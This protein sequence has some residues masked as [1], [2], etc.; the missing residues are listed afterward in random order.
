M[1]THFA[2][3]FQ[4]EFHLIERAPKVGRRKRPNH[5]SAF[6]AHDT[7][8]VSANSPVQVPAAIEIAK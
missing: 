3:H 5:G 2:A 7:G 6:V 8:Y 1:R 4:A